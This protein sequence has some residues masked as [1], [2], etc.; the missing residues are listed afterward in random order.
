MGQYVKKR[1]FF[2][3]FLMA[4]TQSAIAYTPY[5]N[6]ELDE[7]EKEF[8]A[9]INHAQGVLKDPLTR[10]YINQLGNRLSAQ[11][12]VTPK[13]DFFIVKSNEI[14]AFAGPGGHIGLNTMLILT[15]EHESELAA[16]MAHEIA[17][18]RQHHLYHMLEHHKHMQAPMLASLLAGIALGMIN[19][20]LG[21][22][23]MMAT[24]GGF[25]QDSINF[26]RANEKEADRIGIDML[27][28]A[29]F[30]PRGMVNFFKRMHEA[31]RYSSV[32][33]PEIL[34]THPLDDNRVAEAESRLSDSLITTPN[35]SLAY[36]L[37]KERI[38]NLTSKQPKKLLDRYEDLCPEVES[39]NEACLYGKAMTYL[40]LNKL[41]EAYA[42][43]N[44]LEAL[45][46]HNLFY[47]VSLSEAESK[48]KQHEKAIQRLKAE[49]EVHPENQALMMALAETYS[50]A[51]MP[52][53]AAYAFL[54]MHRTHPKDLAI[55]HRLAQAQSEN[56]EKAYAYFTLAECNILERNTKE[57][58][59]LL[60]HALSLSKKNKYL[61][62]RIEAKLDEIS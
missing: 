27:K 50:E 32:K 26:I 23:A 18:V 24:L 43:L 4:I 15:S 3:L 41:N 47:T 34:R 20:A 21:Q 22:G 5:S 54:R 8:V 31:S 62:A 1:V 55:C 45:D 14:N 10:Q 51:E 16:V 56:K 48:L 39:T 49:L 52:D 33:V 19:P 6:R 38:R 46:R 37:A 7:I 53:K 60:K 9:Q 25:A 35:S 59:R 58:K 42:I 17:H 28:R 13:P 12:D 40:T 36:L 2:L 61:K 44:S 11:S 30:D 57:A 29:G